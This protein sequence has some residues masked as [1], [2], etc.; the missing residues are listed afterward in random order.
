M[1]DGLLPSHFIHFAD[2]L[3]VILSVWRNHRIA[4][5]AAVSIFCASLA[6]LAALTLLYIAVGWLADNVCPV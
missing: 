1:H 3:P 4:F 5:Y 2:V 6:D